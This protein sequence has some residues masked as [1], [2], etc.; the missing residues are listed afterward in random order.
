MSTSQDTAMDKSP[1]LSRKEGEK[2]NKFQL[3]IW[4][5]YDVLGRDVEES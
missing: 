2:I 5:M 1:C 4:I 3:H